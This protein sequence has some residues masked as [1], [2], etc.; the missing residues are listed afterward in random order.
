MGVLLKYKI[1]INEN[2]LELIHKKYYIES[3]YKMLDLTVIIP[4]YNQISYLMVAL[5]SIANQSVIPTKVIV[6]DD[7]SP[8]Y[9]SLKELQ[10]LEYPYEL[11]IIHNKRNIGA[12]ESRNV[13]IDNSYTKYIAFLDEDDAW[14][15]K[16]LEIQYSLME[17]RSYLITSTDYFA[18]NNKVSE[19]S[20]LT[21]KVNQL[22]FWSVLFRNRVNTSSVMIHQNVYHHFRFNKNLRYT[23][24]YEL[25]L[26]I[27]KQYRIY[28]INLPL[29]FRTDG[30]NH[31]GLSS[32]L[33]MMYRDELSTVDL[34]LNQ[35]I[36]KLPVK[37]FITVKLLKRYASYLFYK[38][39]RS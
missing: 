13:G 19:I 31:Q 4:F 37:L 35:T 2:L 17:E 21:I 11:I 6:V 15:Q 18:N 9:N 34:L 26:R 1:K 7:C 22:S 8:H 29:T 33:M 25:W 30:V 28:L 23:Q 3:G 36:L 24:D 14:H 12:A 5:D 16:K 38:F 32:N 20:E 27:L 10:S 39:V